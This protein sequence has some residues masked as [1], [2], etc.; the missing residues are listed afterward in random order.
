MDLRPIG[1]RIKAAREKKKLTQEELAEALFVSRTAIS[2]WESGINIPDIDKI[3]ALS[4]LFD[5][6]LSELLT[7]EK[8]ETSVPKEAVAEATIPDE[9]F[10]IAT[11]SNSRSSAK[12][13]ISS[14]FSFKNL[15]NLYILYFLVSQLLL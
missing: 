13:R 6:S 11:S 12:S 3:I 5:V 8:E 7:G 10:L 4:K 9:K 14:Y 15:I 1:P 2:K